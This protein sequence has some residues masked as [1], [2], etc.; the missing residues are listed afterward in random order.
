MPRQLVHLV[1]D[2][3]LEA[4]GRRRVDRALEQ[5]RHLVDAA[6]RRRVELDIVGKAAGIDLGARAAAVA[7]PRSDPGFAIQALGEDA[8]ERRLADAARPGEEISVVQSL[9]LKSMPQRAH[10]MLLADQ[11]VEVPRPPLPRKYL[12]AHGLRN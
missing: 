4:A 12:I 9:L 6:I 11:T 1:D 8:R 5:L 2:V 10:H 7:R 3:N